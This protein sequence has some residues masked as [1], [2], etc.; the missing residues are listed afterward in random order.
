MNDIAMIQ[1]PVLAINEPSQRPARG[2]EPAAVGEFERLLQE[3]AAQGRS[4]DQ[5]VTPQESPLEIMSS[6]VLQIGTEASATL[7]H[8][9]R[10]FDA[11]L[12]AIDVSS[13]DAMIAVTQLQL[14][15]FGALYQVQL[16]S[17]VAGQANR[18]FQTLLHIQS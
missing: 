14:E 16:A 8:E 17:A 3:Y 1:N 6:K 12:D 7:R 18:G 10:E 11:K 4:L 9:M 15:A 13:P 2:A 5:Y